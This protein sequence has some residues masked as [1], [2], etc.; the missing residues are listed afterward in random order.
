MGN[1]AAT[2]QHITTP[3]LQQASQ[4]RLSAAFGPLQNLTAPL[5]ETEVRELLASLSC[6]GDEFSAF[7]RFDDGSYCR[8]RIFS[9]DFVDV[10]LLCWRP[11]QR[12]PIHDHAG[13][14]CGVYVMR[15]EAIEIGFTASGMGPL[16]PSGSHS[17]LAG[18]VTVSSDDDIHLVANYSSSGQDLVT[19]HCY[20]PPLRSMRIFSE[21]E[22]FFSQYSEVTERAT[23]SGCYHAQL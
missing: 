10:L 15:G 12:T 9:N 6:C 17:V 13:S 20:S 23:Q 5:S 18:G 4:L 16:I 19:V 21:G 2:A 11:G 8:N 7:E 22:T 14:T 3:S 1:S